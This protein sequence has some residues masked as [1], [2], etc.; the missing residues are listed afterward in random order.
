MAPPS[1]LAYVAETAWGC[2]SAG[3]RQRSRVWPAAAEPVMSLSDPDT[4]SHRLSDVIP[5]CTG[6]ARNQGGSQGKEETGMRQPGKKTLRLTLLAYG[7]D[8]TPH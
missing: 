2:R 1:G 5:G 6:A 4:A 7:G 3:V 8:A